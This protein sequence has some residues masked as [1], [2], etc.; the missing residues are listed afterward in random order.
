MGLIIT[1]DDLFSR[2]PTIECV[3][4]NKFHY[5]FVAKPT[6]HHYLMEWLDAYDSLYEL[7]DVDDK[8]RTIIYQWMNDVPLHGGKNAIHVNYFC[9]TVISFNPDGTQKSCR[10][11]SWV[12]DLNVSARNVALF[13]S[14]AK[15]RWKIENECF[16]TLKNQGYQLAHNY[17]HGENYLSFNF[18]QL[19][20]LAFTLHQ[21]SELC[22]IA[23]KACR[24]KAGS[25]RNL[26]EKFRTFIDIAIFQTWEQLLR[27]YLNR[28][29]YNIIDGF[30]I[31]RSPP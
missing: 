20:L 16:N 5:F 4:E 27:Y 25:K 8:G 31:E 29:E 17:G 24:K 10:T 19:T 21:I 13:V 26:W 7:R 11:S 18:Y 3:L 12:T 28:D 6:S 15:T 22:D 14:G 2:Q 23:F 1:G 30:V 9:K